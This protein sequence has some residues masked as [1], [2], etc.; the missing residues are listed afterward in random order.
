MSESDICRRQIL[1]TKVYPRAVRVMFR[2]VSARGHGATRVKLVELLFC[3]L[4]SLVELEIL[5]NQK[6]VVYDLLFV[7][8][9]S[10][11]GF[12]NI[13]GFFQLVIFVN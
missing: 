7:A 1:T 6:P 4:L 10:V 11:I 5:T 9:I 3:A 8:L 13:L 12:N 2:I